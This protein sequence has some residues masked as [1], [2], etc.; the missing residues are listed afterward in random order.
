MRHLLSALALTGLLA[1]GC[2]HD[3]LAVPANRHGLL[4]VSSAR[5][6]RTLAER[7]PRR[8]LVPVDRVEPSIRLDVRYATDRNFMRRRLYPEPEAWLRCEAAL[9]LASVQ[10]HLASR[11]LGLVVFDAYRPYHVTE[12]MWEAIGDPDYVADPAKG[13]RH[14]RG[15]A[16]DVTLVDLATGEPLPM[17]TAY[18]D[19][20][21]A[22]WQD[23]ASLPEHVL[24]NR[25][26]LREAMREG[27]FEPLASEW[28]H[29][30]FRDWG[31]YE[32]LDLPHAALSPPPAPCVYE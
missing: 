15:A 20:T 31:E 6:Y 11:G 19:F 14:N 10:R 16:V 2:A 9:A 29:F 28:W 4:V 13:S 7:T 5:L 24:Q 3:S 26:I 30:D 22:A 1:S 21:P 17:P 18:D 8:V 27:G 32:L 25:A 12:A 23:Y